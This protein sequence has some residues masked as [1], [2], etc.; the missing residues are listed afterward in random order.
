MVVFLGFSWFQPGYHCIV[1]NNEK[2]NCTLNHP[3]MNSKW[4]GS[5]IP[6]YLKNMMKDKHNIAKSSI[7]FVFFNYF[8]N[9][10]QKKMGWFH[11]FTFI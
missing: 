4:F 11:R 3:K 8:Q 6:T 9:L 10:Q 2:K 5:S 7:N 1:A